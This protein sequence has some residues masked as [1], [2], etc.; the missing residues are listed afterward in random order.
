[1]IHCLYAGRYNT[2]DRRVFKQLHAHPFAEIVIIERGGVNIELETRRQRLT[3]GEAIY[4]PAGQRHFDHSPATTFLY[5]AWEGPALGEEIL[6]APDRSGRLRLMAKWLVEER[7]SS[8]R[9]KQNCLDA[10][11][12]AL[13]AEFR[14]QAE[15][16]PHPIVEQVRAYMHAHLGAELNLDEL[17]AQVRVSKSHFIRLYREWTGLTPMQDLRQLRVDAA[18]TLL[19][20][21]DRPLKSIAEAVGLHDE[22]QLS[23]IFKKQLGVTPGSFR[24]RA[25][26]QSAD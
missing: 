4:F 16:A 2:G 20:T 13:I 7:D 22:Y 18:R 10:V 8:Y 21:T 23:K 3:A 25:P 19:Y 12:L 17:A 14:K 26:H 15:F 11:G 1:M 9:R 6:T 24:R 5:L